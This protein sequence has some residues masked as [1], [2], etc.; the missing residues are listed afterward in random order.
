M[1]ESFVRQL[2]PAWVADWIAANGPLKPAPIYV[3]FAELRKHYA[4]GT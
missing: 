3:E 1:T 4:E 2:Y